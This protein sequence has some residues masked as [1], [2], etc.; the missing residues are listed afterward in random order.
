MTLTDSPSK[1]LRLLY[2]GKH[3]LSCVLTVETSILGFAF[4]ILDSG[5]LKNNSGSTTTDVAIILSNMSK[6]DFLFWN[7]DRLGSPGIFA[8]VVPLG[9][10]LY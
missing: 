10:Q 5:D 3:D 9:K 1:Q 8:P 4:L 7:T 6:S 2:L